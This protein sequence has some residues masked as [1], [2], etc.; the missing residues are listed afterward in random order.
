MHLILLDTQHQLGMQNGALIAVPIP[1]EYEAIGL[2]IQKMVEQAVRES[3][4]NGINA[5]GNDATPW[6][7]RRID[8]LTGSKSLVSNVA[9]LKNA[10]LVGKHDHNYIKVFTLL[11][12]Y[13]GGKIAQEYQNLVDKEVGSSIQEKLGGRPI[14]FFSVFSFI[15]LLQTMIPELL[16]QRSEQLRVSLLPTRKLNLV[17]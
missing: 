6:L 11:T 15:L 2:E 7:L 3:E 5:S 17:V 16:N 12:R 14:F 10:A 8:E 1:E 4:E 9:L 13:L